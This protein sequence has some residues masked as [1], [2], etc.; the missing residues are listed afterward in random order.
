MEKVY[1]DEEYKIEELYEEIAKLESENIR[2]IECATLMLNR[3]EFAK[4]AI[5]SIRGERKKYFDD[6]CKC[7]KAN[8]IASKK[9]FSK[10]LRDMK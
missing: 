4:E 8:F 7:S 10:I 6:C 3:L 1:S 9:E 2:L 5:P